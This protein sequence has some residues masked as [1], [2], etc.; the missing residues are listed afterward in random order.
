MTPK[1]IHD[2]CMIDLW[3][4]ERLRE[5]LDLEARV[6]AHGLPDDADNLRMLK[7]AGFSDARLAALVGPP[8]AEP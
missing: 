4:I 3:F 6:R 2:A 5:I 8:D 7:A 1:E